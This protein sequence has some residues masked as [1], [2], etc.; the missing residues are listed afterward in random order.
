MADK[1]VIVQDDGYVGLYKN[2][3]LIR[4]HTDLIMLIDD[5]PHLELR[6]IY[7]LKTETFPPRLEDL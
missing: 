6:Q 3:E 2:G 5:I 7:E 4:E 1:F